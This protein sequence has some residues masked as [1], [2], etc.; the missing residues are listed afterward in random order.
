MKWLAL[1]QL[2]ILQPDGTYMTSVV[3]KPEPME[4]NQCFEVLGKNEAGLKQMVE[5][6]PNDELVGFALECYPL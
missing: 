3:V 2:I 4:Q 6:N 5:A 1:V